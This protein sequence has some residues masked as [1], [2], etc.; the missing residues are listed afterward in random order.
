L[1][2][3]DVQ[4]TRREDSSDQGQAS[5]L[6]LTLN[7]GETLP[8]DFVVTCVGIEPNTEIGHASG[9]E[10]DDQF[11]GFLVNS[12]FM[13]KT[14]LWVAGDASCF[15]DPLLGR[16][17]VE[18]HDH[19]VVSGRLAGENMAGAMKQY[20]HQS[21]IW[22]DLGPEIGF[23]AVGLVDSRLPTVGIFAKPKESGR[24]MKVSRLTG[25]YFILLSIS[26]RFF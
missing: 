23:E 26:L 24:E 3:I 17:R 15:Y 9:L 20:K 11:G 14:N 16:R 5:E 6:L 8:V 25:L 7:D 13:A 22:S 1:Q 12:E 21:M 2:I 18:H 4:A 10:V 19:A